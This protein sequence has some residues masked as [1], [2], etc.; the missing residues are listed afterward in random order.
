MPIRIADTSANFASVSRPGVSAH[1][2]V[3]R[4]F[5]FYN[6]VLIRRGVDDRGSYLD[7][8]VNC[9]SPEDEDPP[10]WGNAIWWKN[11]MWYGQI[12]IRRGRMRSLAASLDIIGHELTHG[13]TEHTSGLVYRDEAGALDESFSDIFGVLIKNRSRGEKIYSNPDRWDWE[14]GSG[15]GERGKPLRNM[16]NP[17]LT[18]DP[19]HV[20]EMSRFDPADLEEDFGGVHTFSNIHNKAAYNVLTTRTRARGP[21]VFTPDQVAQLYYFTLQRLDRVATFEDVL[22]TMLD[23]VR[24]VYRVQAEQ[25]QKLDAVTKAYAAVGIPRE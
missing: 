2:N 10:Q 12:A 11:K 22:E 1:L 20:K 8:M 5:Q 9:I 7:N 17:K 18:G 15:L 23:V 6:D 3:T 16:K 14:I 24:T 21:F 19:V 13:V 4:V 25:T